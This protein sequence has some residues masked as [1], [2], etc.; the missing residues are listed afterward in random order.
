MTDESWVKFKNA[1]DAVG[2]KKYQIDSDTDYHLFNDPDNAKV[3][4]YDS[5]TSTFYNFRQRVGNGSDGWKDPIIVTAVEVGD[6]HMIKFGASASKIR[7]F[8]AQM[9]LNLDESQ[10]KAIININKG[11]Y[12]INPITG[13][14]ILAGFKVLTEEEV[15]QL[16]PQEKIDYEKKLEIYNKRQKMGTN[17]VVQITY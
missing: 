2:I 11:N 16:S 3:I 10:E 5:P 13:D 15:A 12:D 4:V 9:N 7:E 1:I 6:I 8:I 17:Q 14:Y